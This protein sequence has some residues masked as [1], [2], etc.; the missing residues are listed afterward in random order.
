MCAGS[1]KFVFELEADNVSEDASV[2]ASPTVK[3]I[4]PAETF[5][6]VTTFVIAEM[7]G[8]E[9][10]NSGANALLF[11]ELGSAVLE[12]TATLFVQLPD[13]AATAW[14]A[15]VAFAALVIAPRDT[16]KEFPWFV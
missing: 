7:V 14:I 1:I 9:F 11:A 6:S 5:S 13:A 10:T 8:G 2:S 16:V 4:G 15:I 12:E 3:P